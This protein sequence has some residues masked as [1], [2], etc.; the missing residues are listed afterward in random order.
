MWY[1]EMCVH[2]INMDIAFKVDFYQD[3]KSIPH[4]K[5]AKCFIAVVYGI[6]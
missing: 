5:Y 2:Y 3:L 6:T 1:H 4:E